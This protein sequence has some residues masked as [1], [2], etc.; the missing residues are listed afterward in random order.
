MWQLYLKHFVLFLKNDLQFLLK[1]PQA[2]ES[3]PAALHLLWPGDSKHIHELLAV[4]LGMVTQAPAGQR[5]PS[6][7]HTHGGIQ[8]TQERPEVW[9]ALQVHH[10]VEG[11]LRRENRE[12]V[13][14]QRVYDRSC[15]NTQLGSGSSLAEKLTPLDLWQL[16][17]LRRSI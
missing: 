10:G 11:L 1:K 16:L 3:V 13:H 17:R 4:S 9:R 12:F 15:K 14:A 8:G 7:L 6:V 5:H 2:V